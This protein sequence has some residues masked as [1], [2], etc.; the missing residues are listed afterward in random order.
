MIF[1]AESTSDVNLIFQI[2]SQFLTE[3][4]ALNPN[5]MRLVASLMCTSDFEYSSQLFQRAE[6]RS[7]ELN[8]EDGHIAFAFANCLLARNQHEEAIE[9]LERSLTSPLPFERLKR[10]TTRENTRD[11]TYLLLGGLK[12]IYRDDDSLVDFEKLSKDPV[13]QQLKQVLKMQISKHLKS[14]RRDM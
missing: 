7:R 6:E 5:Y 13:T 1:L 2:M 11:Q 10:I 3:E 14:R 4:N 9:Q 12:A 8:L